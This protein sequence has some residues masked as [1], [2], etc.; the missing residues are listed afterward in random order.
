MIP[1]TSS[2]PP[3]NSTL[4]SRTRVNPASADVKGDRTRSS[5]GRW[6]LYQK[7][8]GDKRRLLRKPADGSADQGDIVMSKF[9][10]NIFD[11]SRDGR[12]SAQTRTDP[13]SARDVW[14]Q[15]LVP[16]GPAYPLIN[17]SFFETFP[18]FSPDGRRLAFVS[19]E[20]G[21][22]EVYLRPFPGPGPKV[23]VSTDGGEEPLWSRDG[24]EIFFHFGPR[25]MSASIETE[26]RLSASPPRV[27]FEGP[28]LN[29][30]GY[31]YDVAPDGKRFL[32]LRGIQDPSPGGRI[33]IILKGS[34]FIASKTR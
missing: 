34:E 33:E 10:G 31:A 7:T 23:Q 18:T 29:I 25:W 26:P 21:R 22:W 24:K 13:S 11:I 20:S 2:L 3:R 6:I 30:G 17:T 28:Y 8:E 16:P 32:V 27:L 15:P 14:I 19:D 5:D 9:D 1:G 4:S 12:F